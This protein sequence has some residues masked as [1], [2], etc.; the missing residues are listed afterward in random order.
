MPAPEPQNNAPTP[1]GTPSEKENQAGPLI[2]IIVIVAIIALGGYYYW[3][4]NK[5][6]LGGADADKSGEEILNGEDKTQEALENQSTSSAYSAIEADFNATNLD[7]DDLD[8][9]G[10]E[11]GL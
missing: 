11:L 4:Q 3:T 6:M 5:D 2:G 8:S 1:M 7:F 10:D 9:A